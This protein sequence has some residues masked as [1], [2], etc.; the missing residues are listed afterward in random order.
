MTLFS[1]KLISTMLYVYGVCHSNNSSSICKYCTLLLHEYQRKLSDHLI[2][3]CLACRVMV[4]MLV[5][6]PL[7]LKSRGW[8]YTCI[9]DESHMKI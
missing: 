5:C 6:S 9:S 1:F 8:S 7:S 4:H 2:M 3:T